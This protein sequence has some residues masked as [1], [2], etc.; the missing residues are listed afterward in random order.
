MNSLKF[1]FTLVGL[2]WEEKLAD[3]SDQ[4]TDPPTKKMT[5]VVRVHY[6]LKNSVCITL[7]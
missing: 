3:G 7:W 1:S 2:G 4:H 5:V 6:L